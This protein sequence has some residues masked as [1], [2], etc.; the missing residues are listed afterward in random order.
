MKSEPV[1]VD[2]MASALERPGSV[3]RIVVVGGGA[4]GLELATRLGDK[5]GKRNQ[6]HVTLIEKARTHFWKPHLH[7]I[8]AGGMDIGV[9]RYSNDE[10]IERLRSLYQNRGFLSG[11]IINE[12]E[13]MP[14]T[15][16]YAHRFGSLVRA[17][18]M[19][20]FTPDRDYRYLEINKFLRRFHPEIVN[21]TESQIVSLGGVVRRDP[22]TDLLRVNDEFSI[23]LVLARCQTP[24]SCRNH[25]KVRFDTSL[26]PDITVAVRLVTMFCMLSAAVGIMK[27][28]W[29]RHCLMS[30]AMAGT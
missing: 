21:Q 4:G 13:G 12:T 14:S 24:V 15:S 26:A 8:A 17:Y 23:S 6:A 30:E 1:T 20:G 27:R 19:V 10:L 28:F 3:H 9:Y 29:P 16:M 22:A 18:Q 2:P 25:W 5:L 11:L 7:E